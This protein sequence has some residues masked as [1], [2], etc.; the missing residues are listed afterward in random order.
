M[1][2]Q[3]LAA[4]TRTASVAAHAVDACKVYGRGL[5]EV[6]ALDGI[7]VEFQ[8]GQFTAIMGPSGSGKSTLL[9]CI[10]GLDTLSSGHAYIGEDDLST[11]SDRALTILRRDQVGFIFQAYNL[12]PT[13]TARENI[14]LPLR[15]AG[16]TGDPAWIDS[17]IDTLGLADRLQHRPSEM[18]GGQQQRVAVGRALATRPRIVFADEPTGNL[19]PANSESIM[20]LLERINRTGTTVVM[21]THD[22]ALVDRM[23]RRVIELDKGEMIRDQVRG[24]YGIDEGVAI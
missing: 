6:R 1:S 11:L 10:A 18:S 8:T 9:H 5:T 13:L 12:V 4:T 14:I 2:V 24:V 7:S 3:T 23:R 15:L 16:R 22:K 21:A 17:V 19:D 20:A